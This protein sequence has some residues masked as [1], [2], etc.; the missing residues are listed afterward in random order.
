MTHAYIVL[1]RAGTTWVLPRRLQRHPGAPVGDHNHVPFVYVE[2]PEPAQPNLPEAE[3]ERLRVEQ[4]IRWAANREP[5]AGERYLVLNVRNGEVVVT[6]RP[7]R[8]AVEFSFDNVVAAD[9]SAP[10]DAA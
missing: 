3:I 6:S 2:D 1:Q 5:D 10:E 4:A 7:P 9:L 8:P